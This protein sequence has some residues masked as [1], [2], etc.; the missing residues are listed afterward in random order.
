MQAG[1][2]M[3]G[4]KGCDV[5]GEMLK[6]LR[7]CVM[8]IFASVFQIC[9]MTVPQKVLKDHDVQ[10]NWWAQI[11]FNPTTIFSKGSSAAG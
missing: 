3:D 5:S 7:E 9:T 4:G 6:Q 2:E 8:S 1:L 10:T 11:S